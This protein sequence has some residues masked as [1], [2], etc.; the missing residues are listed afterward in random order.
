[1]S[2]TLQL[3]ADS[4]NWACPTGIDVKHA[5]NKQEVADLLHDWAD[6]VGRYDDKRCASALVWKGEHA[7]VTDLYPDYE[8]QFGPRMGV[9]WH[10]A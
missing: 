10:P 8:L 5:F 9:V 2:Y 6:T 7:D 1:M 4:G 3:H